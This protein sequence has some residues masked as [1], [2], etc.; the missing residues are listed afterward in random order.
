MRTPIA[1][2]SLSW[3][4]TTWSTTRWTI[5]SRSIYLKLP[6]KAN[7]T[8]CRRTSLPTELA[9]QVRWNKS[10][11]ALNNHFWCKCSSR[12]N[13]LAAAI[14]HQAT[15]QEKW[16]L[17]VQQPPL[18]KSINMFLIPA[19]APSAPQMQPVKVTLP[20]TRKAVQR[21]MTKSKRISS[22][23][24]RTSICSQILLVILSVPAA[25]LHLSQA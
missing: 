4:K 25:E 3:L 10:Q 15:P 18:L 8:R 6:C 20:R 24:T 21:P 5:L 19:R 11:K 14:N 13:C 9:L 1:R 12:W 23:T 22:K 17:P 16:Q 2:S 7:S